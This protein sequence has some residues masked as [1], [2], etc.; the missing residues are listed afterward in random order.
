[1]PS[2]GPG[3]SPQKG[4]VRKQ[5][6]GSAAVRFPIKKKKKQNKK[7][8]GVTKQQAVCGYS[9]GMNPRK[10]GRMGG[11]NPLTKCLF[12]GKTRVEKTP[13]KAGRKS[14]LSFEAGLFK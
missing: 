9:G 6:Y 14:R 5:M 3:W 7:T 1:M 4:A 8:E 10:T 11:G 2:V 12:D 13:G